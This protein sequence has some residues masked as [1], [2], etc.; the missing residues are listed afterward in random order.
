MVWSQHRHHQLHLKKQLEMEQE[1]LPPVRV[2]AQIYVYMK[3]IFCMYEK[4][5]NIYHDE[6]K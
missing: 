2:T 1:S 4:V 6:Y 5:L 3:Q